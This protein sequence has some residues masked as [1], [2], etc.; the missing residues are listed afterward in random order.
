MKVLVDTSVWSHALRRK[1][2][3]AT[4]H[5]VELRALVS[6]GRV[7]LLGAIRQEVLSGIRDSAHF[8]RLR[9]HL[10]AFDDETLVPE[11]YERA[12]EWF[13]ACRAS[14]VQGSNTDFLICA[15]GERRGLP[16][17]TTDS[18]F[19]RF[20]KVIPLALHHPRARSR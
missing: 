8:E 12:A 6:E 1:A 15:A 19:A 2:P 13:N 11:D 4:P 5:V 20:S 7:A 17:L 9:D 14:G 3:L 10:H 18:D 16:I